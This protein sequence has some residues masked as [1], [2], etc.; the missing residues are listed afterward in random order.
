[1]GIGLLRSRNHVF[2]RRPR[3]TVS[4]IF[5]DCCRKQRCFLRDKPKLITQPPHVDVTEVGITKLDDAFAWVIEAL[6]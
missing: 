6:Y 2:F 1:M 5:F 4:D 3:T